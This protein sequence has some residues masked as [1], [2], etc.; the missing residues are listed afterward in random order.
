MRTPMSEG[1]VAAGLP[2]RGL[3]VGGIVEAVRKHALLFG[4]IALM[5]AFTLATDSF[6]TIDNLRNVAV[7]SS[8][9]LVVGVPSALL[10]IAGYVDLSVGSSLA[11]AAVATGLIANM[12]GAL[13]GIALGLACG[14]VAGAINGYIVAVRGFSPIIATLGM[15]TLLRG[16]ALVLGPNPIY[17]FP[18]LM[19]QIGRG[20]LLGV[21]YLL[22]IAL[23]VVAAG[24]IVLARLPVGRHIYAMGVNSRAAYLSGV[25]IRTIGFCLYLATGLAAGLAGVMQASRLDSAP[26][27]SLGVGFELTALTAILLGGV[28]FSGGRGNV[29]GVVLGIWFLG[30]LQNG[31][32]LLNVLV[33]WTSIVTGAVLVGA[34]A[35]D[36]IS[37]RRRGHG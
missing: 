3:L 1:T 12:V 29:F 5:L 35:L 10:V 27:E 4:A 8:I 26:S 32:T 21:P 25:R 19:V 17:D 36:R 15:L 11:V 2:R 7:Q 31:L 34:A 14:A 9:I 22:I 24:I 20:R 37:Q 16:V 23:A 6:L 33:S 13:P 18:D 28:S 30:I